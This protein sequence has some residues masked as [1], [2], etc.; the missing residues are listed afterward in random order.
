MSI[1]QRLK[2]HTGLYTFILQILNSVNYFTLRF[3]FLFPK[4]KLSETW[5]LRM[6]KV[7]HSSDNKKI[8]HVPGAGKINNDHQVMH[9]GLKITLGSYYDYGMTVLIRENK[10]VHEPEEEYAFQEILKSIPAGGCMLE[11]GSFWAFY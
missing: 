11:L 4:Y 6:E 2:N 8:V 10:G 7:M 3:K 9:N 5:R 1:K